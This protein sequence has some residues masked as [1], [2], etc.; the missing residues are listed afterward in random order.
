MVSPAGD[1][2]PLTRTKT[3]GDPRPW[4]RG[5]GRSSPSSVGEQSVGLHGQDLRQT[6]Y[7]RVSS[8]S[9]AP[10]SGTPLTRLTVRS[11]HHGH[12]CLSVRVP[13]KG[14]TIDSSNLEI[15]F[16]FRLLPLRLC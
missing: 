6:F 16:P 10:L 7:G 15:Y 8:N 12:R 14:I 9:Q 3:S 1:L 5:L 13:R 2:D 11:R 4:G